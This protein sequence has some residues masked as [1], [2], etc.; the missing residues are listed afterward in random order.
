MKE[1]WKTFRPLQEGMKSFA[2]WETFLPAC[3]CMGRYLSLYQFSPLPRIAKF[4]DVITCKPYWVLWREID[5]IKYDGFGV[6]PFDS[7]FCVHV[8]SSIRHAHLGWEGMYTS[9]CIPQLVCTRHFW[10]TMSRWWGREAWKSELLV[11]QS[12]DPAVY[13]TNSW[14]HSQLSLCVQSPDQQSNH[15]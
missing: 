6:R 11:T 3:F 15:S 9:W 8:C 10:S 13:C 5:Q 1:L 12:T 7:Q 4:C 2:Q 14:L